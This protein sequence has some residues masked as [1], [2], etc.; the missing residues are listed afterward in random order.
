MKT[1]S[2]VNEALDFA[3]SEEEKAAKLYAELAVKMEKPWVK[4]T[5]EEF[6]EEERGHK[7][8]LLALKESGQMKPAEKKVMDLKIA[9]YLSDVEPTPDMNYQEA[10]VFAMKA[11]KAAFK[12]YSD[13]AAST[14]DE[15]LRR[16][17]LAL[18]Q[19]EAKHKLRFEIEY[20]DV[21][22]QE[23]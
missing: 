4:K 14:D 6:A 7:K 2:S 18:A 17:F 12:L 22:L 15:E 1:F 10:L 8:R 21:I 9:D 23:D 20:D 13:L 5:L 19:E 16:T 11:E 3:I